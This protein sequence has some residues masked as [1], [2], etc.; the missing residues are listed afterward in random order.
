MNVNGFVLAG[1][2]STRMS[3]DKALLHWHGRTLL[4][5]MIGLLSLAADRVQVV[6][7][8]TIPDRI[9]NR[10]PLGG[11]ATA[12]EMTETD[13]N[14]VVAVDLPLLTPDFLK[15]LRLRIEEST[16]PIVACKLESTFPLCLGLRKRLL[17]AVEQCLAAGKLSLHN[18][19]ESSDPE[20]I[21]WPDTTIFKNI[22]T[23]AD[24]GI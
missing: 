21:S 2:R 20:L 5:H 1:G 4:D 18:I 15:H 12:L 6:G 22:N 14:L 7:R 19:I 8:D 13:A 24:L 17:P 10:G 11:I 16:R 23:P 9:P 3:R